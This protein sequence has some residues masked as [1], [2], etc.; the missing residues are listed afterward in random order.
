MASPWLD[1]SA[2]NKASW[3][4]GSVCRL[5]SLSPQ[6]DRNRKGGGGKAGYISTLSSE[7]S[8]PQPPPNTLMLPEP[9][10]Q[11]RTWPVSPHTPH[12]LF[13]H[14]KLAPVC[15]VHKKPQTL[16]SLPPSQAFK[17]PGTSGMR[18]RGASVRIRGWAE[19][20]AP[21]SRRSSQS[22]YTPLSC[23]YCHHNVLGLSTST[24]YLI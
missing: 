14:T 9:V 11:L 1:C 3:Y 21:L 8:V 6:E 22:P 2:S 10:P 19:G 20:M 18:S 7:Q 24:I 5:C 17:H 4:C 16:L 12:T 13:S 23:E 15:R